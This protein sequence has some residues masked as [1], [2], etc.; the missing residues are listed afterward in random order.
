[1][2]TRLSLEKLRKLSFESFLP[3]PPPY[4]P[5]PRFLP[6]L[7]QPFKVEAKL[8]NIS[9]GDTALES[10][11]VISVTEKKTGVGVPL[12]PITVYVNGEEVHRGV[13]DQ[14]GRH[15]YR[16]ILEEH[17]AKIEAHLDKMFPFSVSDILEVFW[18]NFND[19]SLDKKTWETFKG[20]PAFY[21]GRAEI[22]ERRKRIEFYSSNTGY[23]A[24]VYTVEPVDL[25]DSA[26]KATLYSD[27][28]VISALSI[29]PHDTPFYGAS[30]NKGYDVVVWELGIDKF[31]I[32]TGPKISYRKGTLR[33]NPDRVEVL[34]EGD[35][36][37]FHEGGVE[38]YRETYKPG[39]KLCNIYLWGQSWYHF[40]G[41][42]SWADDLIVV[43]KR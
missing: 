15:T 18:D 19:N 39:T 20:W 38:V 26:V 6:E 41:G 40:K 43:G 23:L 36:I 11:L 1:M 29:L 17:T 3:Q 14:E 13:C 4:P 16:L 33:G 37:S 5:L 2:A 28:W 8:Q 21:E 22:Y 24:G 12:A 9:S 31:I 10:D 35:T 34:I 27:D 32:Y 25:S 42:T 30:Y 7:F